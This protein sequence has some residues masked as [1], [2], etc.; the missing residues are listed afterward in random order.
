MI[1]GILEEIKKVLRIDLRDNKL[2]CGCSREEIS[3]VD[4]IKNSVKYHIEFIDRNLYT[5]NDKNT[6]RLLL[7]I[8]MSQYKLNCN[9]PHLALIVSIIV[10]NV[11]LFT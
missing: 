10:S 7:D 5:C 6:T 9:Y 11:A 1:Y 3:T 4:I 2:Q 8:D